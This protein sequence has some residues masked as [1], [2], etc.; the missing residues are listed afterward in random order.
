MGDSWEDDDFMP[1]VPQAVVLPSKAAWDD[2]DAVR[3]L[4]TGSSRLVA[5]PCMTDTLQLPSLPNSLQQDDPNAGKT[6]EE[7]AAEAERRRK[8]E[9]VR[10]AKAAKDAERAALRRQVRPSQSSIRMAGIAGSP[11]NVVFI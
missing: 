2:E 10:K 11:A 8:A 5:M 1:V 9:E 4:M 6:V 3:V 7:I